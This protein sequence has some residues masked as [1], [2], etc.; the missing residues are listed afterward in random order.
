LHSF[1]GNGEATCKTGH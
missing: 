1:E